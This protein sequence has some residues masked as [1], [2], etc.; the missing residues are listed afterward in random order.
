MGHIAIF[1]GSELL[2]SLLF[3]DHDIVLNKYFMIVSDLYKSLIF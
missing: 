1:V 3:S 2:L